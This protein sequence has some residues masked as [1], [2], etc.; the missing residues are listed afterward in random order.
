MTQTKGT[1]LALAA[2]VVLALAAGQPVYS[3]E[4]PALGQVMEGLHF[5]SAILGRD[6]ARAQANS[7]G[8]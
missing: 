3:L 2:G 1:C 5:P 6:P 8:R 7:S 4:G